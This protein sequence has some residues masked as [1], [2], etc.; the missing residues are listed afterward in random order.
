LPKD[1]VYTD[2]S[3]PEIGVSTYLRDEL[4]LW[5]EYESPIF[6][7]DEKDRP[8]VWTPDFFLPKLGM[9]IE[10][11]GSEK[12]WEDGQQ[13]YQYRQQIYRNNKVNVIFIHYWKEDWKNHTTEM[14]QRIEN[15]RHAEVRKMLKKVSKGLV[16]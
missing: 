6:V 11:V 2:M 1:S 3:E 5:W 15:L 16:I 7:K 8:R 13:N 4:S 9:Y 14:I 10:V 12:N